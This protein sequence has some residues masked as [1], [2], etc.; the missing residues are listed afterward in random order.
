MYW[1]SGDHSSSLDDP[2]QR[3]HNSIISDSPAPH[4][5]N[6]LSI[7]PLSLVL[8]SHYQ[9]TDQLQCFITITWILVSDCH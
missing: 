7:L 2:V 4:Q 3:H 9:H 5:E 6:T 8:L 1:N